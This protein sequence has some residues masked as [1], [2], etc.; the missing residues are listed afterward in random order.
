MNTIVIDCG[1]SFIKGGLFIDGELHRVMEIAVQSEAAAKRNILSPIK[2]DNVLAAVHSILKEFGTGLTAYRLCIANEMHGFLLTDNQQVP[3]TDYISWQCELGGISLPE[4]NLSAVSLLKKMLPQKTIDNTGMP[5]RAGLPSSNLLFLKQTNILHELP[6]PLHFYTL[7]DYILAAL[8]GQEPVM[9]P[10]NAAATGLFNICS[11][12]WEPDLISITTTAGIRFPRIGSSAIEFRYGDST[13]TAAPAIGDQQAALLGA[14]LCMPTDI[15]F[16]LGTGAQ[17]SVLCDAPFFSDVYQIRPFF[18]GRYLKTV[19]HIPCGRAMNVFSRFIQDVLVCYN[20]GTTEEALWKGMKKAASTATPS[21]LSCD[22]SFFENAVTEYSEGNIS[23]I[24]EN[25]LTLSNLTAAMF[26]QVAD[27][28]LIAAKRIVP[29]N[30]AV[31][32]ILFSGGAVR[33]NEAILN[34]IKAAYPGTEYSVAEN[35]TLVGLLK[36]A[37]SIFV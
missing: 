22:L 2:I 36:F 5:L 27:N 21:L 24:S 26:R 29:D 20:A 37:D 16:N 11:G 9:H 18:L 30:S 3:V 12:D 4:F 7:G 35:E 6:N 14:G 17:V 32:R 15:S 8:S 23:H 34:T 33:K 28:A 10:T 13:I 25:N 31:K 19:P 1:A